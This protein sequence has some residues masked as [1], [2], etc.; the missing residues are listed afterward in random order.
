MKYQWYLREI[1]LVKIAKATESDGLNEAG[2]LGDNKKIQQ[3]REIKRVDRS[4]DVFS[5]TYQIHLHR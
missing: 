3:V 2:I 1:Q 5:R 4:D